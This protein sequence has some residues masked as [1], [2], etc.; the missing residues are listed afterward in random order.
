MDRLKLK[1][2][3]ILQ[4]CTIEYCHQ[5]C[6]RKFGKSF[7][8]WCGTCTYWKLELH[9][10]TK[11]S[12]HWDQIQWNKINSIIFPNSIE[13]MAKVFVKN[14]HTFRQGVFGDLSALMSIISNTT[15]FNIS[16][17]EIKELLQIRDS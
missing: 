8:K 3:E 10:I 15:L 1:H 11:Y 9:R 6:S 13:E 14:F 4:K 16:S 7:I 12:S 5:N 17:T 2:L